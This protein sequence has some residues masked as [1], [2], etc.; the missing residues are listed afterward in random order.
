MVHANSTRDYAD[1]TPADQLM[2][3]FLKASINTDGAM[4]LRSKTA[5][6]PEY[7][8]TADLVSKWVTTHPQFR[9]TQITS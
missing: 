6:L 7:A 1:V 4:S 5:T 8:A 3:R 9:S 2:E